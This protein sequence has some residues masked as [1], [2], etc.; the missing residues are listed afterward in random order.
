[1]TAVRTHHRALLAPFALL[2]LAAACGDDTVEPAGTVPVSEPST[3]E[4]S[5]TPATT[6]PAGSLDGRT[7]LSVATVDFELVAGTTVRLSFRD[8]ALSAS[9]GC[10]TMSGAY[11]IDGDTLVVTSLAMTEMGCEQP[12]MDQ[13]ERL[14]SFLMSAPFV[15]LEGDGLRLTNATAGAVGEIEFLDREVADPDRPLEG[16]TWTVTTLISGDSASSIPLGATATIVVADGRA[17]V[18]AGCNSG[19][20]AVTVGDGILTFGPLAL[21]KM[22]CDEAAMVLETAVVAT[23]SGEVTYSIEAASLTLQHGTTGLVLSTD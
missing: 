16:T 9:A 11:T 12:L 18:A 1:M 20:A 6:S 21:T 15:A 5:T 17:V 3:N 2:A 13:D 14:A 19:S 22:R 4:P 23:L 7:F 10:N 8:G